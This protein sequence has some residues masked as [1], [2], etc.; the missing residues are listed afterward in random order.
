MFVHVD[1]AGP[2]E[3]PLVGAL[4]LLEDPAVVLRLLEVGEGDAGDEVDLV[5]EVL[6]LVPCTLAVLVLVPRGTCP[7][8]VC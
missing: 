2:F 3:D 5:L 7:C 8:T 6:V 4:Q 1:L